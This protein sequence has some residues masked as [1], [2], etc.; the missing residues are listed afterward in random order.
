L[1]S[2][3]VS[4]NQPS[5]ENKALIKIEVTQTQKA[6]TKHPEKSKTK[7]KQTGQLTFF[8][9]TPDS[10]KSFLLITFTIKAK[11][12]GKNE[13]NLMKHYTSTPW[14]NGKRT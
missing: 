2:Q 4:D 5:I 13:R 6:K 9:T 8:T 12:V 14:G 10:N 7:T 3:L 11:N 1:N